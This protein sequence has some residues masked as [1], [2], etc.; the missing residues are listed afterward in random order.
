MHGGKRWAMRW[1]EDDDAQCAQCH[2]KL[3]AGSRRHTHHK[4]VRCVD[5]H[6][7]KFL[8]GVLH[9]LRDHSLGSPE[10]ELT[11]RFQPANSP[12][13][14]SNCHRDRPVSWMRK[15]KEKWWRPA[16]RR[17]VD[18]VGLVV[19]LRRRAGVATRRLAA[20]AEDSA[21]GLFFRLTA[22][23][24]LA[25]I[26][27]EEARA[28][29][30]RLLSDP[31]GEVRQLACAGIAE[32]P[33]PDA[34]TALLKLLEDPVRTVRVEA[35]Y[36]LV[37]CGWRGTTPAFEQVYREA[38]RMLERQKTFDDILERLAPLADACGRSRERA[39]YMMPLFRNPG[40]PRTMGDLLQRR[41]RSLAEEGN[42]AAALELYGQ[43][44]EQYFRSSGQPGQ[45]LPD[46]LYVDHAASL[47]AL[48]RVREAAADWQQLFT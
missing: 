35:A 20:T 40:R 38:V 13:A 19:D 37:R 31:N 7:P 17:L 4:A 27:D 6:M 1:E 12:N 28:S 44:V 45:T 33:Q 26:S 24:K 2:A 32:N 3:T 47:Y 41:G 34:V 21:N 39:E 46:L 22:M 11:E 23:Q 18:N 15:W 43:A 10:P 8:T 30:R 25:E 29:L 16:P 36:A 5:C 42:H 48:G 9:T 14:C